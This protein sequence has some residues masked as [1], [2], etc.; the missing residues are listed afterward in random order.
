[1]S[2]EDRRDEEKEFE[3]P[4]SGETAP[5]ARRQAA[6]EAAAVSE[7]APPPDEE[8]EAVTIRSRPPIFY[9]W[10]TLAASLWF[11]AFLGL[12]D[13]PLPAAPA[14]AAQ[15]GEGDEVG[16]IEAEVQNPVPGL[17]RFIPRLGRKTSLVVIVAFTLLA[18]V[19]LLLHL[20][21]NYSNSRMVEGLDHFMS[22]NLFLRVNPMDLFFWALVL[23]VVLSPSYGLLMFLAFHAFGL[24]T[25]HTMFTHANLLRRRLIWVLAAIIVAVGLSIVRPSPDLGIEYNYAMSSEVSAVFCVLLAFNLFVLAFDFNGA[26]L[27]SLV[28]VVILVVAIMFILNVFYPSVGEYFLNMREVT[29]GLQLNSNFYM[30]YSYVVSLLMVFSGLIAKADYWQISPLS[31]VHYQGLFVQRN[32]HYGAL[33]N[34]HYHV[35]FPDFFES[36]L[37]G[38]SGTFILQLPREERPEVISDVWYARYY[39]KRIRQILDRADLNTD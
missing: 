23:F 2:E 37:G 1:V 29:H 18:V 4:E 25:D 12:R 35:E 30:F 28:A 5:S 15:A 21:F 19:Y 20:I 26:S 31:I 13:E 39:N 9:F 11:M 24:M 38:W 36:V 14:A 6:P 32:R 17:F 33:V 3:G 7:P 34:F 22:R 16:G 27:V 8:E 10:P